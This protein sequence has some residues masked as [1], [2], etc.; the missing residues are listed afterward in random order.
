ML[1]LQFFIIRKLKLSLEILI[2]HALW[3]RIILIEIHV[4]ASVFIVSVAFQIWRLIIIIRDVIELLGR[5]FLF[6]HFS[7]ISSFVAISLIFFLLFI[8]FIEVIHDIIIISITFFQ[9]TLNHALSVGV[10]HRLLDIAL[11][12]L[13]RVIA[14]SVTIWFVD[15]VTSAGASTC[16]VLIAAYLVL[17][18]EGNSVLSVRRLSKC[19]GSTFSA[20]WRLLRV[21]ISL[22]FWFNRIFFSVLFN[23]FT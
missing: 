3:S 14:V 23:L 15:L 8:L 2:F 7:C 20:F 9:D 12:Y 22:F 6:N 19:K 10:L 21:A 11:S 4:C 16:S 13:V 5:R 1:R 18:L 17:L